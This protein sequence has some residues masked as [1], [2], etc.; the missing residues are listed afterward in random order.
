MDAG[1][2]CIANVG[3]L[4]IEGHLLE[5]CHRRDGCPW[6]KAPLR[7]EVPPHN[8]TY[9]DRHLQYTRYSLWEP[10]R[11]GT[12]RTVRIALSMVFLCKSNSKYWS[13]RAVIVRDAELAQKEI[14]PYCFQFWRAANT[15]QSKSLNWR[16]STLMQTSGSAELRLAQPRSAELSHRS[17]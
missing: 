4:V 6:E 9:R 2:T 8:G 11:D 3:S 16:S 1:F 17:V 7:Q 12:V 14:V 5:K 10:T 15:V 13:F